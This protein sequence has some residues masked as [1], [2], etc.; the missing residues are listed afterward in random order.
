MRFNETPV[1]TQSAGTLWDDAEYHG[2]Q[3]TLLAR[4]TLGP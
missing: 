3:L 1:F 4:P 2:L